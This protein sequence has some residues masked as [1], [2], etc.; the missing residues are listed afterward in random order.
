MNNQCCA[1]LPCIDYNRAGK[2]LTPIL[3]EDLLKCGT[4][5]GNI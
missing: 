2:K 5:P 3:A 4:I 1:G